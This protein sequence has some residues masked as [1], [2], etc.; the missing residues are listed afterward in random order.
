MSF[1]GFVKEEIAEV[2]QVALNAAKTSLAYVESVVVQDLLP[3][4]VKALIAA[5]EKLGELAVQELLGNAP[6]NAA[7][8]PPVGQ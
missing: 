4:T 1:I 6:S 2:D 8:Q 5:I 3:A 7:P